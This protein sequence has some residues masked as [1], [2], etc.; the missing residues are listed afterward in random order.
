MTVNSLALSVAGLIGLGL[1][2]TAHAAQAPNFYECTG[3]NASVTLT[4]GNDAQ[5]GI[6]PAETSLQLQIGTKSYSFGKKQITTESTLIGDLWEV[7]LEH[8]PDLYLKHASVIIPEIALGQEPV[9]FKSQ[10]VLT[11]VNTP[12]APQA[13]EGVVNPSRYVDLKC[14]ASTVFF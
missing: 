14:T 2:A 11:T 6:L 10:L 8:I 4:V 12:F 7:A 1:D 5:V 9:Q 13:F 3:R